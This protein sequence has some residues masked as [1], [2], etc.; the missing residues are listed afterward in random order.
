VNEAV[1]FELPYEERW[2]AAW[3]SLGVDVT[4]VA[5]SAGHA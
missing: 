2:M 1:L 4:S 3:R 5:P